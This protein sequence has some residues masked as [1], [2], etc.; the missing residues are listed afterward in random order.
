MKLLRRLK[1]PDSR[2]VEGGTYLAPTEHPLKVL[3]VARPGRGR[4]D[5]VLNSVLLLGDRGLQA[6]LCLARR[7]LEYHA[8]KPPSATGH[9]LDPIN[10]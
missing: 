4:D 8:S 9:K 6:M 1:D 7:Q 2:L 5:D 3:N 10:I